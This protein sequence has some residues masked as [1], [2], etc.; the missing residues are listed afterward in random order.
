[1]TPLRYPIFLLALGACLAAGPLVAQ[2]SLRTQP[3]RLDQAK[4]MMSERANLNQ[5]LIYGGGFSVTNPEL[6]VEIDENKLYLDPEFRACEITLVGGLT[7]TLPARIQLFNQLVEVI[8]NGKEMQIDGKSL[9]SVTTQDGRQFVAYRRPVVVNDP[10]PLL[11]LLA[12]R[13]DM[14]LYG[15]RRVELRD[16][17]QQRSS[18]DAGTYRK[19]LYRDDLVYLFSPRQQ[20]EIKKLRDLIESLTYQD[21]VDARRYAK[22][23]RLRN[24]EEDYIRLLNALD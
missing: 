15:Y 3:T 14:K 9:Q 10:L 18:Y 5:D 17:A 22:R 7:Q 6:D 23:E 2:D 8:A 21:Q 20:T 24:R 1:M 19:R 4:Q 12:S 16:P 13:G 11:E